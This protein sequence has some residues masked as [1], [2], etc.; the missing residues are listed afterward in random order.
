MS[1]AGHAHDHAHGRGHD[2]HD[3]GAGGHVHRPEGPGA[4][5][6]IVWAM[7]LTG[8]FMIA[9]V[10]GGILSGSLALIADAGHMLTDVAALALAHAGIRF[11]QRPADPKR[12]FGYRRL[13]VLAAFV[14]G[15]VLLALTVWIAFE[16]VQRF[17]A[18]VAVLSGPML[19]IAVL[20]LIV[21]LASFAILRGGEASVNV[22][23][24]LAHVLGDLL[25]SVAAIVA[26]L[27][28]FWTGWTPIDPLLS[29]FVALLIVRSG[30]Q[31][32]RRASHILLEGTPEGIDPA[33][34]Q[35]SLGNLPG[36]EDAHHVHVWSVT[37]GA[38]VATLHLRLA[39][40]TPQADALL[41]AKRHLAEK[42]GITHS[43]V[44][45]DPDGHCADNALSV[46]DRC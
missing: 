38:V 27:V 16:A 6:R 42:F 26:A 30:W 45:I 3:H 20:G 7:V 39:P 14:N 22:A 25:G 33:E 18:P 32:V 19:V 23:G 37:S 2:G 4:A 21:N 43:T 1:A 34:I 12:T 35:A 15:I 8:G 44:E 5:R 46:A 29:V 36:I 9:E 13:E 11:G 40:G 41:A 28:I 31:I 10:V 17:M 24:A